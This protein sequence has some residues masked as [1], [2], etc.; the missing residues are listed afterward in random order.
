MRC[1]DF[2]LEIL[3]RVAHGCDAGLA[4]QFDEGF[5][6]QARQPGPWASVTRPASNRLRAKTRSVSE[7]ILKMLGG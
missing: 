7:H 2:V 6:R 3:R 1:L 4:Q 5:E